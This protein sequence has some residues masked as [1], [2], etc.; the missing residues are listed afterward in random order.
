MQRRSFMSAALAAPFLAEFSDTGHASQ[1]AG[2][3]PSPEFYVWR[4]F[5][6]RTGTQPRRL[7]R[8]PAAGRDPGA[9]PARRQADRRVRDRR[10]PRLPERVRAAPFASLD[11][12]AD[13][14]DALEPMRSSAVPQSPTC[15]APAADPVYVRQEVS[16]LRAF[17]NVPRLEVPAAD[18][19]QRARG[20]SSCASTRATMRPRTA[21]RWRCSPGWA[22]SRSSAGS[23]SRRSSS[24]GR[25]SGRGCPNFTY[26]LVHESLAAREKSWDAFRT[27]PEWKK[28]A[29]TPGYAT[30]RS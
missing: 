29:A 27:D 25:S 1:A 18:G 30:P 19:D 10:R 28:L 23:A 8:L 14:D 6:L 13:L 26:M 4:Q 5:L 9:E 7:A 2:G 20:C 16:L 12:F 22:S 24:P 21:R 15:T 17:P 3:R 11:A